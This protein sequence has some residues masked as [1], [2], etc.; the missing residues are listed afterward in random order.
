M[1]SKS[2]NSQTVKINDVVAEKSINGYQS[3]SKINQYIG[4]AS[5]VVA[6]EI[7]VV[8]GILMESASIAEKDTEK[9][10]MNSLNQQLSVEIAHLGINIDNEDGSA[11]EVLSKRIRDERLPPETK[12]QYV[13]VIVHSVQNT[14]RDFNTAIT[15]IANNFEGVNIKLDRFSS[16]LDNIDASIAVLSAK[17][18]LHHDDL[19]RGLD[20]LEDGIKRYSE[21]IENISNDIGYIEMTQEELFQR[22]DLLHSDHESIESLTIQMQGSVQMMLD[23]ASE[24]YIATSDISDHKEVIKAKEAY[25]NVK[26]KYE[27]GQA[28]HHELEQARNNWVSTAKSAKEERLNFSIKLND[29]REIGKGVSLIASLTGNEELA[30][31]T[32]AIVE[33]TL[34]VGVTVLQ[35]MG[36]TL[37]SAFNPITAAV[38]LLSV[39]ATLS[40]VFGNN[41]QVNTTALIMEA[42]QSLAMQVRFLRQEMNE[43]FD[44]VMYEMKQHE[45]LIIEG[46]ISLSW[47]NM[48]IKQGLSD[49]Y[50]M[51]NS[52]FNEQDYLLYSLGNK[53]S[54]FSDEYKE[55][56]YRASKNKVLELLRLVL[57]RPNDLIKRYPDI[58]TAL[59][60]VLNDATKLQ[61]DSFMAISDANFTPDWFLH[62]PQALSDF[63]TQ[64]DEHPNRAVQYADVQLITLVAASFSI[65][66]IYAFGNPDREEKELRMCDSVLLDMKHQLLSLNRIES[67]CQL[68][69]SPKAMKYAVKNFL[70]ALNDFTESLESKLKHVEREETKLIKESLDN[71][72]LQNRQHL[73]D[74]F[75]R[76]GLETEFHGWFDG[77]I[78]RWARPYD[79]KKWHKVK[80][81]YKGD[82]SHKEKNKYK[83][84]M[85][86]QRAVQQK[87]SRDRANVASSWMPELHVNQEDT[88]PNSLGVPYVDPE[89]VQNPVLPAPK[90]LFQNDLITQ[91]LIEAKAYG[92]GDIAMSY[93]I[94]D[95]NFILN[96]Y[97]DIAQS[98]TENEKFLV[99]RVK[100]PYSASYHSQAE[101]VWNYWMGGFY[102]SKKNENKNMELI[103]YKGKC[104]PKAYKLLPKLLKQGK[105]LYVFTHSEKV[106]LKEVLEKFKTEVSKK[107]YNK[108]IKSSFGHYH[109]LRF[110]SSEIN[111]LYKLLVKSGNQYE[112]SRLMD[113]YFRIDLVRLV[114][115]FALNGGCYA[116]NLGEFDYQV[117][118][119]T[120][121]GE[122]VEYPSQLNMLESL[123]SDNL[124]ENY[125][126][127]VNETAVNLIEDLTK[128]AK[129]KFKENVLFKVRNSL[130]LSNDS[131]T[132]AVKA[133]QYEDALRKLWAALSFGFHDEM[134]KNSE[135][136]RWMSINFPSV[137]QVKKLLSIENINYLFS[138]LKHLPEKISEL[139]QILKDIVSQDNVKFNMLSDMVE[140]LEF[141][142]NHYEP[143]VI[144]ECSNPDLPTISKVLSLVGYKMLMAVLED[145]LIPESDKRRIVNNMVHIWGDEVG[146]L[147]EQDQHLIF[148][149]INRYTI[150]AGLPG[151]SL[152]SLM[153]SDSQDVFFDVLD[154]QAHSDTPMID[155]SPS[156]E[157]PAPEECSDSA[158][159]LPGACASTSSKVRVNGE[160][161]MLCLLGQLVTELAEHYRGVAS[162]AHFQLF[163]LMNSVFQLPG[164]KETITYESDK[165]RVHYSKGLSETKALCF[166]DDCHP[167]EGELVVDYSGKEGSLDINEYCTEQDSNVMLERMTNAIQSMR[168][169]TLE[170]A[171]EA[172]SPWV[173]TFF[174]AATYSATKTGAGRVAEAVGVDQK[175]IKNAMSALSLMLLA[176]QLYSAFQSGGDLGLVIGAMVLGQVCRLVLPHVG[177]D[178]GT[179]DFLSTGVQSSVRHGVFMGVTHTCVGFFGSYV[180]TESVNEVA[181]YVAEFGM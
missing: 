2:S 65:L 99:S 118:E 96:V 119:Y 150:N 112:A 53:I 8:G 54:A 67:L 61:Q 144:P 175:H 101:S 136:K 157:S 34:T 140:H 109:D 64:I 166:G 43:R 124:S 100:F 165:A 29:F 95:G 131:P 122:Y 59:I 174:Y 82:Y 76:N 104:V 106:K 42:I 45:K 88:L 77:K 12:F 158:W 21:E 137:N 69:R 171:L 19:V 126:F 48:E 33:S 147:P 3:S 74:S 57:S 123:S 78:V 70:G 72:Q 132:D 177:L 84:R 26:E 14:R 151:P 161:T 28:D 168:L 113:K 44:E 36:S 153:L 148:S 133:Y 20:G 93:D 55:D 117:A 6:N 134:S 149:M 159:P 155:V 27:H 13:D 90:I 40:S 7:P 81:E 85:D 115:K 178:S 18:E 22:T 120:L 105:A 23:M 38:N 103:E 58:S 52:R 80:D 10:L 108:I 60:G 24:D 16:S 41:R 92:V 143:H 86:N 102:P 116:H 91:S 37:V 35:M 162:Q 141:V 172:F 163:S 83:K 145:D 138:K 97:F 56:K 30:M 47:Q 32:S 62:F 89:N 121:P 68:S 11:Y 135:L 63:I 110:S 98:S 164:W 127:T 51:I 73:K 156:N 25:D 181:D 129:N 4:S 50:L 128:D 9:K 130:V 17:E 176:S 5:R 142:I 31:Q 139:T 152:E 75:E 39:A 1:E 107:L 87:L 79:G 111:D 179:A 169:L 15:S 146:M 66:N 173:N 49:L 71:S 46:F 154:D 114:W 94:N 160:L 167:C 125:H 180:G 170:G